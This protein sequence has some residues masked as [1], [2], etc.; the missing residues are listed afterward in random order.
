MS[1]SRTSTVPPRGGTESSAR[2]HR[3]PRAVPTVTSSDQRGTSM[4]TQPGDIKTRRRPIHPALAAALI[5]TPLLHVV[6]GA[7]SPTL[8]AS[9]GGQLAV[10]AAHPSRWYWYS[11]LLVIGSIVAIPAC[12]GLLQ[13]GAA[14]MRRVGAIGGALVTLG[15][16]GSV[17][18]CAYQLWEWQMVSS[19]ASRQQ[20]TALLDRVD[21]AAGIQTL[22]QVCGIGLLVGTVMLTVALVR[23]ASVPSWAAIVF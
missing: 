5:I 12:L 21:N 16:V 22:F 23:S 8:K 15:F 19:G 4:T 11:F 9:A 6:G 2:R 1:S 17:M 10:I 18:D 7:L 3:R 20:M 14:G 13:L